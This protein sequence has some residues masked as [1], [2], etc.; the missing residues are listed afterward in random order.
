MPLQE[1]YYVAEM[2]VGVAVLI[3]IIFVAI[4]LRQNTYLMRATMAD[5]RKQNVNWFFE[6]LVADAEFRNFHRRIDAEW[7]EFDEDDRDRAIFLGIRT[8][9]PTLDELVAHFDGQISPE[10]YRSL[11]WKMRLDASRPHNQ[12][13]YEL[14]KNS[15]PRKIQKHYESIEL[16]DSEI[17]RR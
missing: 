3:S 4:E 1:M 15:Y 17:I 11:E 8:I 2:L 14:I 10:E 5:Q 7:N 16:L 9:R 6:Q 12:K 13:A